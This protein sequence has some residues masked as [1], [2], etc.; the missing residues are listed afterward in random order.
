MTYNSQPYGL[1]EKV[2]RFFN[3]LKQFHRIATR[4]EKLRQTFLALIHLAASWLMIG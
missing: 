4:H 3:K 1:R 2:E